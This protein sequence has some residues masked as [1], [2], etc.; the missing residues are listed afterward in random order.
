MEAGSTPSVLALSRQN[1]PHLKGTSAELVA[2]GAYTLCEHGPGG[3]PD[4]IL[5][6][7]GESSCR[8]PRFLAFLSNAGHLLRSP[9]NTWNYEFCLLC[10]VFCV[11]VHVP[12][13]RALVRGLCLL[14][15]SATHRGM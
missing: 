8:T 7:T 1:C 15:C 14:S 12:S 11:C 10:R 13:V 2:K 9:A 4:V 6:A 5:A 3:A